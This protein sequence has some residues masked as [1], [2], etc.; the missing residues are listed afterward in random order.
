MYLYSE[1]KV[2]SPRITCLKQNLVPDLDRAP[3]LERD[4]E[5]RH[6]RESSSHVISDQNHATQAWVRVSEVLDRFFFW[7]F[8]ICILI[9]IVSLV[10]FLRYKE[11]G[12]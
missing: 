1:T 10:G 11:N 2:Q 7:I 5:E 9:P 3:E 6:H 4:L 8:L 12:H